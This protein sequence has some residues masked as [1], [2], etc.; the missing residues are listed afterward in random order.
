MPQSFVGDA[1]HLGLK[2]API[3]RVAEFKASVGQRHHESVEDVGDAAGEDV[4]FRE[5][6]RIGLV[7]EGTVAIELDFVAACRPIALS[8]GRGRGPL[9]R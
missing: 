1:L 3:A 4:R 5:R 6:T 8:E 2:D 9:R 7:V